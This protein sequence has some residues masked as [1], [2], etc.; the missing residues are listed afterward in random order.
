L[1]QQYLTIA[2]HNDTHCQL[3]IFGIRA[4]LRSGG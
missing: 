4:R 3:R 1:R 2:K